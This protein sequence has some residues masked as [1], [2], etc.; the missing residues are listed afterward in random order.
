M[1][2]LQEDL[3]AYNQRS[4]SRK[5]AEQLAT[6]DGATQA[7][8]ELELAKRALKV[9]DI[10]PDFTLPNAQGASINLKNTLQNQAVV[11]SFY[12]GGWCPYCNLELRALQNILPQ[13]EEA[14]V[15]LIAISPQT[16]DNSLTTQEKNELTFEVLSDANN[17]V[18]R[19]FGLV[20]QLPEDLKALYHTF[21]INLATS[22]GDESYE[23]PLP[24]TY[25]INQ[26]GEVLFAF[27]DEDYT[28]RV[29]LD[30]LLT[31]LKKLS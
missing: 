30:E 16:P 3:K 21:N 19:Q 31:Q 13:L 1:N 4:R 14:D 27:V 11:V 12:R 5:T 29:N 2:T 9:G 6:M 15:K 22:N 17:Q 26:Q 10:V 23:L 24:A 18:A 8:Q 7:L 20:H 28:K 25:L